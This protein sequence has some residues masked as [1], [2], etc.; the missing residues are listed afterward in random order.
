MPG[1]R[2]R[3]VAGR[4][5]GHEHQVAEPDLFALD[6]DMIDPRGGKWLLHPRLRVA[7]TGCPG[8]KGPGRRRG[9]VELRAR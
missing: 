4:R 1:Q 8:R 5:Y 9:G 7:G 6:D 3:G 2:A